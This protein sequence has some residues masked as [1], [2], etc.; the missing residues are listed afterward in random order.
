LEL[1]R[2]Q[3]LGLVG[4]NDPRRLLRRRFEER[5]DEEDRRRLQRGQND[6]DED[7]KDQREF[8]RGRAGL[9]AGKLSRPAAEAREEFA[10]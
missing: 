1:R 4:Q 6:A 5:L 8:D 3:R 10:F 2:G 7:R 9:V